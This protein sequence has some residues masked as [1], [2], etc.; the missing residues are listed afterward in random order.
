M[1]SGLVAG[2]GRIRAR[3]ALA[4]GQRFVISHPFGQ[5]ELG[6]SIAVQGVCLTVTGWEEHEGESRFFV[7]LSPETLART[8]LGQLP[9]D[10]AVNLERALRASDRLGGHLVTGHVDAVG[11][12]E[13]LE[14]LGEMMR[15]VVSV[16]AGLSRFVAEKGSLTVEGVSLTVNAVSGDQ[17]ELLLIPHTRAVTTLGGLTDG[18]PVNLEVDLVARYV[19]RLLLARTPG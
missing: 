9:D 19:E 14:A 17:A 15:V 2:V 10:G 6:E 7:E 8:T 16:P 11:R 5:L 3:S 13:R 1:F 18:A 4:A 12:V